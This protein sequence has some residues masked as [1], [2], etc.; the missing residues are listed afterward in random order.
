MG[1][2]LVTQIINLCQLDP[3]VNLIIESIQQCGKLLD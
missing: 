3:A 1:V 2:V